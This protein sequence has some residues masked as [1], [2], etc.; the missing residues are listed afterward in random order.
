MIMIKK[1]KYSQGFMA[2]TSMLIIS[3][4]SLAIAISIS[5]LG[6]S[7]AKSTTSLKYG[8]EASAIAQSCV[9]EALLRLKLN[10]NYSGGSLNVA[11]GTCNI[12]ITGPISEKT[13][14]VTAQLSAISTYTKRVQV[15]T[16][17]SNDGLNILIWKEVP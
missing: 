1:Y 7:E 16:R 17:N 10:I 6:I 9:E 5:L 14:D 2:L 3:A 12:S 15:V 4:I 13:I 11:S 8:D